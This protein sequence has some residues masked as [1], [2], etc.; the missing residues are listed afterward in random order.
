MK[1]LLAIGAV[2]AAVLLFFVGRWSM[3]I[4]TGPDD[5]ESQS[6][7][8]APETGGEQPATGPELWTCPMHP[9]F[10]LPDPGDCPICSMDLVP[11]VKDGLGPRQYAMSEAARK[12]A[13]IETTAVARRSISVPVRLVGK[14]DFDE[15]AIKTIAS[16]VSG[17]LDR[18][19]VD[20]TGVP[21]GKGEHL[22]WLYSPDLLTAQEEL[23]EAKKRLASAT[24]EKSEFLAASNRKAWSSARDKLLLWGLTEKQIDEI[25]TRGTAEDHMMITSPVGGIVIHK[26]LNQGDY[27]KEGTRIYQIADLGQLWIR[28]DAYEQD[29]PWIRYGQKV[30]IRTE[31]LPGD[32]LEG[33]I[34]FIDPVLDP[35]TRTVKVRVNVANPEGR[36]KPGM[37]VRALLEAKV[38][39]SGKVMDPDLAGKWICPMHPEV[40]EDEAGPCRLCG[41]PLKT[42]EDLGL[43]AVGDSSKPLVV[44]VSAVLVTGR[45]A[46]VYVEVQGRKRPTY[47]GREVVLGARAGEHY[48]IQ[49]GLREG[50][51]VVTRG[52][53]RIDSSLQIQAKPSMMSQGREKAVYKSKESQ[54]FRASMVPLHEAYHVVME[55]LAADDLAEAKKGWARMDAALP[56][57]DPSLLV[58]RAREVWDAE[59]R[60]IR[61]ALAT[62]KQAKD[63]EALRRPFEPISRSLLAVEEVFGHQGPVKFYR[64]YCPMAFD[65][66]G[67]PWIQRDDELR[68]P[69]FGASM[70]RCGDIS[71]VYPGLSG[72]GR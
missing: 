41:M 22:V 29:L 60:T 44:P 38:A 67:A 26:A 1:T 34:S 8:V 30:S 62:G 48:I 68:N 10:K 20:Y 27:V 54:A 18:L 13:R 45:R 35:R 71:D 58:R 16:R 42:A 4:G 31:S 70:Y 15:T 63:I 64:A 17:R 37:F 72:G 12:L 55:A 24:G 36:L 21:V 23:L 50:E 59:R 57:V 69:Y 2:L 43:T 40:V 39:G 19:Y 46:V 61:A 51:R 25:E 32:T 3:T 11:F 7:P 33:W 49:D 5:G 66:K 14:V 28:L 9:Q 52:A 65:D 47:E 53:F 56:G 6:R